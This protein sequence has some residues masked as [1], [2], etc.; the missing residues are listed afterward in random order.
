MNK[1]HIQT[2]NRA[3]AGDH[4]APSGEAI[5]MPQKGR[6]IK[7]WEMPHYA[8][9]KKTLHVTMS[10]TCRKTGTEPRCPQRNVSKGLTWLCCMSTG[11]TVPPA[12]RGPVF[13]LLRGGWV[14]VCG[15]WP[16]RC[17][18]LLGTPLSSNSPKLPHLSETSA[19]CRDPDELH[20][21][22]TLP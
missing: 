11:P 14:C 13:R 1:T 22:L 8:A 10:I 2:R 5:S 3:T 9:N 4:P 19:S 15:G 18:S 6:K 16:A 17:P 20:L 7:E 21:I 12:L